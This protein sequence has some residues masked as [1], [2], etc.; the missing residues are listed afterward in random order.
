MEIPAGARADDGTIVVH[1]VIITRLPNGLN[2][3][4]SIRHSS[5]AWGIC[6]ENGETLR[7]ECQ[8]AEIF[9]HHRDARHGLVDCAEKNFADACCW[10][11]IRA[12]YTSEETRTERWRCDRWQGHALTMSTREWRASLDPLR[13]PVAST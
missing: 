2:M 6:C 11:E 13:G 8:A 10:F 3:A 12:E 9:S 7:Q 1:Y 4:R 5:P